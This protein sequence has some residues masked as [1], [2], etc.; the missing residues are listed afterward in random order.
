MK[1][2][3]SAERNK[4]LLQEIDLCFLFAQAYHASMRFAGPVRKELGIRTVFILLAPWQIQLLPVCSFWEFT[5]KS[6]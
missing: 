6:W 1:I 5:K 3:L 4:E 2:D